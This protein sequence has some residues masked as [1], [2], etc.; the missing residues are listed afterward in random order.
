MT[1]ARP[2][3][4]LALWSAAAALALPV[5]PQA[6][7]ADMPPARIASAAS[8]PGVPWTWGGNSYGELGSGTTQS[9]LT[10]GPVTGLADVVDLHGGREHVAALRADGTVWTWGSNQQG[11]LGLGT[12]GNRSVPTQVTG[13]SGAT[14]VETGHNLSL[15]LMGDGTVR[16][17]GLNADGQLGDGTTTL[18]R[19]PVTVV[20]LD[21]AVAVA[22]GRN[23][24]YALRAD[25]TVVGWGRNDE[26]QLGDG[27]RTRRLTPVR[28]GSLTDVVAIAGGRDH[29]LALRGDG[30]VWAWGSNDYGQV[31]NGTTTDQDSPVQVTSGVSQV[32]AGAHHSYA[33]RTDGTVA[34]WGRNYR[35]NLGD[36][37]TATRTRP[38]S[39]RNLTSIVSIG[40]G[41]DT[42][43][44]VRSDGRVLAWGGNA[45]GQ[46][47][48][49]TTTNRSTPVLVP[50]VT[51]AVLAGGGGAAYSVVLVADGAPPAP[52]DPVAVFTTSCSG[53]T[54]TFDGRGSSD[55]DGPLS[56]Y[57]WDYGDGQGASGTAA[58]RT[59]TYAAAGTY[60]VT[61]TVTDGS[62]ATGSVGHD[63]VVQEA[64]PGTGP[65]FWRAASSD[66]NTARPAVG[67]PA[68]V[69][70]TDRL[71]LVVTTNRTATLT[72]PSG[73]TLAGT[74]TDGTEVRSWVLTRAAGGVAGTTQTLTLDAI[75]KTSLVLLAYEGAG[76]PSAVV[77]QPE[78]GSGTTHTAPAA[79][80]T[81]AGSTVVRYYADKT[82]TVH[83]WTLP[84]VLTQRATTTGS[85]GGMLTAVA[86]DQGGVAAGTVPALAA[87]AGA[88]ASKAVAWTIVLPP[89]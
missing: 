86:G 75:S 12:T 49:G 24:S 79:P 2:L 44:A 1:R 84:P 14:A 3:R 19:S 76:A 88:S 32:I 13:I 42:G 23:M 63:V 35:A 51:D 22:A 50:G 29:G 30:T 6:V 62:G 25:G 9:R 66:S 89:S 58:S 4:L 18:R 59:H 26:G 36:G 40:S 68:T 20:G 57:T 43:V 48:D 80:V 81:Q 41:R 64:S 15:A 83:G 53:L 5:A 37:T 8:A 47:G 54:C 38:V 77:G 34:A 28:V 61:L 31:G 67:V 10:P 65:V 21:D 82:S 17:W 74:V 69:R 11:Q 72:T 52:Q 33:L 45:S 7:G 70:S 60:R 87:T 55:A 56:G 71:V 39:V 27:T 85:S 46:V 16:T 78:T 73:W